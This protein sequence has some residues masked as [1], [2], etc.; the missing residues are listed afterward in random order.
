MLIGYACVYINNQNLDQQIDALRKAG[1]KKI[2]KD[3]IGGVKADR[4][5]LDDILFSLHKGD[6]IVVW[7]LDQLGRSLKHLIRVINYIKEQGAYFRCLYENI[8]SSSMDR[9]IIF[10]V[11]TALAEFEQNIISGRIKVGLNAAKTQGRIGG[12]PRKMDSKMIIHGN[13]GNIRTPFR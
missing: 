11:F 12:R 5:G 13:S 9:K 1:C 8:D 6:T 3:Y 4:N 7:K 10:Q 2:H